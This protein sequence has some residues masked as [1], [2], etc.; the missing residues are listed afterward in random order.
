MAVLEVLQIAFDGLAEKR[1]DGLRKFGLVVPDRDHIP[2]SPATIRAA[3][4]F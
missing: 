4:S 2:A 3:I 1:L